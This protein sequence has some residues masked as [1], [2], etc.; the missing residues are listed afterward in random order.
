VHVKLVITL[1]DSIKSAAAVH[2]ATKALI[3]AVGI[4]S[5]DAL[6]PNASLSSLVALLNQELKSE[7][8]QQELLQ[9]VNEAIAAAPSLSSTFTNASAVEGECA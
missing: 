8:K 3:E 2:N 9:K 4:S 1:K 5:G 6:P 7:E